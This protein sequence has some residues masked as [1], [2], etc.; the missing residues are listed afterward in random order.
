MRGDAVRA[1]CIDGGAGLALLPHR[2]LTL[3]SRYSRCDACVRACPAGLLRVGAAGFD[4][5]PGCLGC[6]RCQAACPTA[7]LR[8]AAFP[9][10]L[11]VAQGRYRAVTLD[12]ARVPPGEREPGTLALPCLGGLSLGAILELC[13]Q[14]DPLP[15]TLL[16]R[17]WCPDCPAGAGSRESRS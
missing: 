4:A 9:E 1:T 2:C 17:G 16:D 13:A 3:G 14:T 15:V 10:A 12:C 5:A 11:A 7:A 8:V 6:G